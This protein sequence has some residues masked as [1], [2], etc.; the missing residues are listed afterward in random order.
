MTA[1]AAARF[2]TGAEGDPEFR[3]I[4]HKFVSIIN[5]YLSTL[6]DFGAEDLKQYMDFVSQVISEFV[7]SWNPNTFGISIQ[8]SRL[9]G[10]MFG[11]ERI[12]SEQRV[13]R[14]DKSAKIVN[15]LSQAYECTMPELREKLGDSFRDELDQLLESDKPVSYEF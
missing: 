8:L 9:S 15:V 11:S 7:P 6:T 10:R 12:L 1:M 3:R 2:R 4:Y 14:V 13:R 5:K